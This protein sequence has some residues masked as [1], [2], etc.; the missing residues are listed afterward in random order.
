V[1]YGLLSLVLPTTNTPRTTALR[2]LLRRRA[3]DLSERV[4][5]DGR[6]E[7]VTL[8]EAEGFPALLAALELIVAC[9]FPG[10]T[11]EA[12]NPPRAAVP[13]CVRC[14]AVT[15]TRVLEELA[16]EV[17]HAPDA[18]GW[19]IAITCPLCTTIIAFIA[20]AS[21]VTHAH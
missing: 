8:C 20:P 12:I 19:R 6:L 17:L 7:F 10:G 9:H 3:V 18:S 5:G 15:A 13:R 1:S 11:V 4:L 21:E 14:G 16:A 2:T